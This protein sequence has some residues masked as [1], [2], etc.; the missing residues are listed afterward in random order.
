MSV[1]SFNI[2]N[3]IINKI[4]LKRGPHPLHQ[5]IKDRFDKYYYDGILTIYELNIIKTN[6]DEAKN[7]LNEYSNKN[8]DKRNEIYNEIIE[9]KKLCGDECKR[10][11]QQHLK[12]CKGFDGTGKYKCTEKHVAY[13]CQFKDDGRC[14]HFYEIENLQE[15]LDWYD[16]NIDDLSK[17]YYKLKNTYERELAKKENRIEEYERQKDEEWDDYCFYESQRL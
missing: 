6:M 4:L 12:I 8:Y 3:E 1:P 5:L 16:E 11:L 13:S 2:P 7:N 15:N 17:E 14:S 10:I 9:Q